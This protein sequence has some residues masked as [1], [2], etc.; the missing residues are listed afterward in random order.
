MTKVEVG[1]LN[2]R[3]SVLELQEGPSQEGGSR[4]WSWVC[5]HRSWAKTELSGKSNVYSIHGIGAKGA[6]FT[7]RRQPLGLDNALLWKGQHCLITSI[8]PLGRLY[9]TVEAALVALS[10]CEDRLAGV[11]FPAV[12][13]ERY[14]GHQQ[15]EPMA[16][17][18]HQRVLV[19]PKAVTLTPGRLVEVDSISWP[20]R[21]AYDLDPHKNEFMLERT[22]DL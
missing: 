21:T 8:R 4:A 11:Q 9:L 13:T 15:M 16:V 14:L 2:D 7:L 12:L 19:T 22:V 18:V 17:N 6:V 1:K 3:I 5:V 20:V 10:S